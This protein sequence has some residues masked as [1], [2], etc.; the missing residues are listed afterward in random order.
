MCYSGRVFGAA[1]DDP[2]LSQIVCRRCGY[3]LT[4]LP[5][6]THCPECGTQDPAVPYWWAV[7]LKRG[8]R[9]ATL[10]WIWIVGLTMLAARVAVLAVPQFLYVGGYQNGANPNA[11]WWSFSAT[12]GAGCGVAGA[13]AFIMLTAMD[14]WDRAPTG[15]R[16]WTAILIL[17]L[18]GGCVY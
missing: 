12:Y 3:D 10:R 2:V 13:A 16:V 9:R 1:P 8:V 18:I 7:W 11:W 6:P 5:D 15:W 17:A 4:G 14:F